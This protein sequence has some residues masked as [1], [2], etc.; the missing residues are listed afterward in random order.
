VVDPDAIAGASLRHL[1]VALTRATK[2]M[3]IVAPDK[4]AFPGAEVLW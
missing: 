4:P 3:G 1:Y 2:R